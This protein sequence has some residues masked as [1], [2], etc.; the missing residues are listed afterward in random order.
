MLANDH[1]IPKTR[2][3]P[4]HLLEIQRYLNSLYQPFYLKNCYYEK[5]ETRSWR[6]Q[7]STHVT[8]L[9]NEST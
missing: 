9:S 8:L 7:L 1:I 5:K 6:F 2:T 3:N 4:K